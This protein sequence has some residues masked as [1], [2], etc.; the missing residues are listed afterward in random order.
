MFIETADCSQG[1]MYFMGI[2]MAFDAI[3]TSLT[4]IWVTEFTCVHHVSW[5]YDTWSV[6]LS[7]NKQTP[8]PLV[9]EWTIPTERLPLVDEI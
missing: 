2:Y 6:Y 3:Y 7:Q 4:Y 9:R 1:H 8:W 5:A